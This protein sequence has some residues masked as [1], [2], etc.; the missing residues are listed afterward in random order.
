MFWYTLWFRL[1]L[2]T[3]LGSLTANGYLGRIQSLPTVRKIHALYIEYHLIWSS[4]VP[5]RADCGMVSLFSWRLHLSYL[6]LKAHCIITRS[7]RMSTGYVDTFN[8]RKAAGL[9]LSRAI[10]KNGFLLCPPQLEIDILS[11]RSSKFL[12]PSLQVEPRIPY[13]EPT[14]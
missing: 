1:P 10:R 7:F 6:T 5:G 8:W 9:M 2:L 13:Y 14:N 12:L 3:I 11:A 4:R